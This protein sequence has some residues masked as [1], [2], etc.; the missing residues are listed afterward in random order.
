ML[1]ALQGKPTPEV[2]RTRIAPGTTLP[3]ELTD[4]ERELILKQ[5]FAPGELAGQ[6]RVVPP[7]GKPAVAHYTLNDG[8]ND[9]G[10]A[11]AGGLDMEA[12]EGSR[13]DRVPR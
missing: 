2:P 6:L 5:S 7:A 1:T 11:A 10:A 13:S 3:L 12:A 8:R 9:G 4:R